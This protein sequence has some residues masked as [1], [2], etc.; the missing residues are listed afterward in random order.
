M[1]A[2]TRNPKGAGGKAATRGTRTTR[3][4]RRLGEPAIQDS[5]VFYI[6]MRE[7]GKE[8]ACEVEEKVFGT[9]KIRIADAS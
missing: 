5:E 2:A 9:E 6:V 7:Y 3:G 8:A 4:Q 1:Y